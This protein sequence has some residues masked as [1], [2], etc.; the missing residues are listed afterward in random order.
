MI[1]FS[2][3]TGAKREYRRF[4]E[5]TESL[6][7]SGLAA[8]REYVRLRLEELETES[9]GLSVPPGHALRKNQR[10]ETFKL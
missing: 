8:M 10:N 7:E 6:Q 9:I 5:E 4:I 3:G 1:G 2:I